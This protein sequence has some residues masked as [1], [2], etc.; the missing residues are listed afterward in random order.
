MRPIAL[1]FAAFVSGVSTPATAKVYLSLM[2]EPFRTNE[3][4][5]DPFDQWLKLADQRSQLQPVYRDQPLPV[6]HLATRHQCLSREWPLHRHQRPEQ[7]DAILS[8]R[9]SLNHLFALKETPRL[10]VYTCETG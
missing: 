2:G 6:C 7:T 3:A 5:E 10:C 9:R 8:P 4:G 1:M